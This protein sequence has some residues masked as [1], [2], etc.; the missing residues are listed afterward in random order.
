M[1]LHIVPH[2]TASS[3]IKN[4]IYLTLFVVVMLDLFR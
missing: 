1:K 2:S 4:A 3:R